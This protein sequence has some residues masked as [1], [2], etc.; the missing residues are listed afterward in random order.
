MP[1]EIL[2]YRWF[3]AAYNWPPSVVDEL[4]LDQQDWFPVVEEAWNRVEAKKAA[5]AQARQRG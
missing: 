3:A 1:E 5:D 4:T 2:T